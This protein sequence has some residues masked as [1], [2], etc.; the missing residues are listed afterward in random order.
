MFAWVFTDPLVVAIVDFF[1][2]WAA[3]GLT[4]G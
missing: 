2:D 3:R 4:V 1:I